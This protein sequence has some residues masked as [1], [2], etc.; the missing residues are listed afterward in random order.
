[1]KFVN[2]YYSYYLPKPELGKEVRYMYLQL[3][4]LIPKLQLGNEIYVY[5]KKN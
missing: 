2:K 4:I 5:M 1:M 3:I